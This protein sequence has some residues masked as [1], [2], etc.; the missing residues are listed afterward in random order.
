MGKRGVAMWGHGRRLVVFCGL[1]TI[2]I[3]VTGA[4]E[5]AAGVTLDAEGDGVQMLGE[6][7]GE[8]Q[9]VS[10]TAQSLKGPPK[11]KGGKKRTPKA[12]KK[13]MAKKKKE[14]KKGVSKAKK[15]LKKRHLK[16]AKKKMKALA[17]KAT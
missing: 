6:D 1:L 11:G 10:S 15:T 14:A 12:V 3:V 7:L 9:S 8:A 4:T 17:K 16:K 13:K 5:E 2:A